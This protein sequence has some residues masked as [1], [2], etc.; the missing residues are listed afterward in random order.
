ML[1]TALEANEDVPKLEVVTERILHQ[2][3]KSRDKSEAGS[4]T[5]SAMTSRKAFRRKPIKCHHCGTLKEIKKYCR[6]HKAEE[7]GR[8][9]RKTK[10]QKAATSVTREN[11]DSKSSGLIASHALSVSSLNE[12]CTCIIDSGLRATFVRTASR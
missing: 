7:E 5:E 9:E 11:S 4:T 3:R 6:Y 12:H 1:V 8:K 10:P 2:E